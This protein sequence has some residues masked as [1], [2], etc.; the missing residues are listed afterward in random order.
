MRLRAIIIGL[1]LS[2]F[3]S[4]AGIIWVSI[5][6]EDYHY[7]YP[8]ANGMEVVEW[9]KPTGVYM[10][11]A[12]I[13]HKSILIDSLTGSSLSFVHKDRQNGLVINIQV[14]ESERC[15]VRVIDSRVTQLVGK[16]GEEYLFIGTRSAAH[17][18]LRISYDCPSE[19]HITMV[20]FTEHVDGVYI[21][22]DGP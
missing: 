2:L 5:S 19:S 18:P 12:D 3:L 16:P 22:L 15:N 13:P 1:A 11:S 4:L 10:I 7:L 20:E 14:Q 8:K 9:W 17:E 21:L 6:I